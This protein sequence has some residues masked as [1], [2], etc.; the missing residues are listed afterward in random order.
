MAPGSASRSAS[1]ARALCLAFAGRGGSAGRRARVGCHAIGVVSSPSAWGTHGRPWTSPWRHRFASSSAGGG[2]AP[3]EL[4]SSGSSNARDDRSREPRAS[5]GVTDREILAA[6]RSPEAYLSIPRERTRAFGIIAHVDHGKSTLADRLLEFTGAIPKGGRKQYLDRLPVERARGITVKAQSVTL[7][8]ECPVTKETYL[9]NLIDTPGHADFSFEVS[10]SL[11]ACDGALLLVDATQGVQAQTIATFFLALENDL[12]ILPVAN[13][14]DAPNADVRAV[15]EQMVAAF[16]MDVESD[17]RDDEGSEGSSE[18]NVSEDGIET[19]PSSSPRG[20]RKQK[21]FNNNVRVHSNPHFLLEAS[22]KTGF[23]VED[24][25]AAIVKHIPPPRGIDETTSTSSASTSSGKKRDGV[26]PARARL[27]DCHY[28][29]Y[30]G[31]VSTVQVV[32]GT[33]RVGDEVVSIATGLSSEILELG[34]MTPEPLRTKELRGGHVGFLVT[35]NRDVK[36]ARIGDTLFVPR[37]PY[38]VQKE[39]A[40][41]EKN[42]TTND[43]AND[44]DGK[45]DARTVRASSSVIITPLPGFKPAKPMVFQGVF[46]SS[47]DQFENLR[48]AIEK[49][50]LNDASVTR[51]NETSVALGP[52]FRCGFLGLLHA[53]VFHQRLAEELG[54]D[55]VATAPT[56]PYR[57]KYNDSS[58]AVGRDQADDE[59]VVVSS[60]ASFDQERLRRGR[61]GVVEEPVVDATIVCSSDVVGRV[62]ELCVERRGEQ[63]E[64]AHLGQTRVMLRYRLPTAEMAGDFSDV[65]KSRTSGYATFDYEEAGFR[66]ADVVRLDVLVNGVVVDALSSLTHRGGSVRKGRDIVKKLKDTLP[67]QLFEVA[68]QAAVNGAVVARETVSAMRKNVIAKCYGGDVSRKKKLLSRQ[69]EGK[70]RMRR[71]GNV[72][73]PLEAFAGLLGTRSGGR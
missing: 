15:S 9:L 5:T 42:E 3:A 34:F 62:V 67:R 46:P 4:A 32:D 59:W 50:T 12:A 20:E 30:R 36:S 35:G 69:K 16:G 53:D 6:Q 64:H 68:V 72:D 58:S 61:G 37:G 1:A 41:A 56:V 24:V 33:L 38:V 2:K 13:K 7:T 49:L 23:G 47:A 71:V 29:P 28:D 52:G 19:T 48:V 44:D 10:R 51:A 18:E 55:V 39:G 63:L 73:V 70:K 40:G 21:L 11:L 31:A 66:V 60:P 14:V 8:H 65:L 43:D 27:L 25:L 17:F 54:V 26:V 57:V 45:N 22:A